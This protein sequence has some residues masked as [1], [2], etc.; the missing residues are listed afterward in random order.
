MTRRF[1]LFVHPAVPQTSRHN[2]QGADVY[3]AG[4]TALV[5]V[6][7]RVVQHVVQRPVLWPELQGALGWS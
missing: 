6:V 3:L 5:V 2:Q 4:S 1:G 7:G